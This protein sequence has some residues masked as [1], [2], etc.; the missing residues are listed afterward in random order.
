MHIDFGM[1]TLGLTP[2]LDRI[3]K[4]DLLEKEPVD[5]IRKIWIDYHKDKPFIC[6]VVQA[7]EYSKIRQRSD[8]C[9]M[10]VLPLPKGDAGFMT[11]FL[12]SQGDMT[13]FTSLAEFQAKNKY[14]PTALGV[15]HF[16]E[17]ADSKGLVLMRG[18]VDTKV[19]SVDEARMLVSLWQVF[20][21]DDTKNKLMEQFNHRP[22]EFDFNRVLDVLGQ[23]VPNNQA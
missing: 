9:P 12:Q 3:V 20:L 18:E 5:N 4:L 7:D 23:N 8:R 1:T 21:L 19:I 2:K 16:A 11:F 14:A 15:Q 17:L 6:G 10:F 22:N 13:N